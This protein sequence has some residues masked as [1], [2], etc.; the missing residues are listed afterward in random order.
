MVIKNKN[1]AVAFDWIFGLTFL[2]TLGLLYIVF[3][4]ALTD[5]FRPVIEGVIPDGAPATSDVILA[6]TEWMSYWNFVP[7][8]LL[9]VILVFWLVSALRKEPV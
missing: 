7:Y 5:E 6:N 1:G 8:F 9:F 4:H 2:F 3:N